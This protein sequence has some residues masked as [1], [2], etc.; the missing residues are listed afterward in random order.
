MAGYVHSNAVERL[1]DAPKEMLNRSGQDHMTVMRPLAHGRGDGRVSLFESGYAGQDPGATGRYGNIVVMV[2][3]IS[4]L[5]ALL[6]ASRLQSVIARPILELAGLA[7]VVTEKKDYLVRAK[8]GT[9]D[10]VGT[11]VEAFNEMLGVIQSRDAELQSANLTLESYNQDL[12][13]K[14]EDRTAALA[15]ASTE[16]QKARVARKTRTGRR[17]CFWRT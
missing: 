7:K 13:R 12:E 2:L 5:A 6:I 14:V 16:A 15:A 1:P 10:E 4:C 8:K 17:A 3:L 11:L 9:E